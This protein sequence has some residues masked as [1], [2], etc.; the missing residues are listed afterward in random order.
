MLDDYHL[1]T[2]QPIH[3]SL[4]Y[5]LD[6][7]PPHLHL[8]MATRADPPLSLARLRA[9]GH[10][11]EIRAADL[12]FTAEETAAFLTHALGLELSD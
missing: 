12:R 3:R 1:I 2:A 5:L 7:L 4:T 9:R 11:T 8:V 10:L 6:H